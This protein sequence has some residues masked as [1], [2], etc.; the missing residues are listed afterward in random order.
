MTLRQESTS[1]RK[2]DTFFWIECLFCAAVLAGVIYTGWF[3]YEDGYL[4]QP[5]FY[6]PSGTFM[7]WYSLTTW[8]HKPGAYEVE[9]TIYP[10]VSFV[11]MRI[12]SIAQCYRETRSEDV[13]PCDWVG[14]AV[15]GVLLAINIL[16]TFR[17]FWKLMGWRGMPRAVALSFGLPMLY[18][19]ERG[20]LVLLCYFCMLVAFGPLVHS[21]R[22]RWLAAGFAVNLKVYVIAA[23]FA[24]LLRR[25]WI[26]TEGMLVATLAIYLLTWIILGEGSP[27]QIVRNLTA[28]SGTFGATA[29]LDLWYAATYIPLNTLLQ[30]DF[31]ISTIMDGRTANILIVASAVW[32]RATQVLILLAAGAIWLRQE[33]TPPHRAVYLALAFALS[34]FE[35]GGYTQVIL[36]MLVFMET[37]R[38]FAR[39]TAIA[40]AF[41]LCVPFEITLGDLPQLVRSSFLSGRYV[42][43][44]FGVGIMWLLRPGLILTIASLLSFVTISD[45]WRDI[46]RNGWADRR[47]GMPDS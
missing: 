42:I 1:G 38:G 32:M 26:A 37:P 22:L 29:A 33:A 25:R 10:P 34:A 20:N 16:A 7:D 14:M 8:A 36:L 9:Q 13:R 39:C 24:P 30:S 40:L 12:F 3:L 41:L 5:W 2:V 28:Y 43:V 19:L 18:A 11:L 4:P 35:A 27:Q 15:F 45:V 21:A 44:E 46:A 23:V 47:R 6:E 31:P 17:A